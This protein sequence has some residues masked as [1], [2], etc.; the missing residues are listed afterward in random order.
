M[1]PRSVRRRGEVPPVDL[2]S[3]LF[4]VLLGNRQRVADGTQL[5]AESVD[6]SL[7][8]PRMLLQP[9]GGFT[10]R[11]DGWNVSPPFNQVL[12]RALI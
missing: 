6:Q 10:Q 2:A 4:Y 8:V 3:E 12:Q 9:F 1:R 11:D 5:D 7:Q